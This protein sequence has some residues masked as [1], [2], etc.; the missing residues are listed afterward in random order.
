MSIGIKSPK[1]LEKIGALEAFIRM[2]NAEAINPS[3]NF[4]YAMIGALENKN[5]VDIA[6]TERE[7]ILMALEGFAELEKELLNDGIQIKN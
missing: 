4:L 2:R 7:S 1:E 3:L 6:R 5:W